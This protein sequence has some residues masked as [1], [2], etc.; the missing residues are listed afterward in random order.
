MPSE[1]LLSIGL[2]VYNGERFLEEALCSIL[3]QTFTD[4][5]LI[6]SD[7]ASSDRTRQ[8]AEAYAERDDRIRYYQSEK[9]MGAGWNMRRVYELAAGKYFK[10]AAVDDLLEPDLLQRCVGIL[11]GDPDCVL[12]YASTKEVDENRI[13]IKNYRTPTKTD[14]T[15]PVARFRE[16][17]LTGHNCYQIFGVIRMSAL[18]QLPPQGTYVNGDRILL[19]RLALLGRFYE[20]PEYLFISRHHRGQ[21]VATLPV[22]L[23]TRRFRLTNRYGT[24]PCTEWWEPAKTRTVSF[25]EFRELLEYSLSIYRTP[26]TARQKLRCY[27]LLLSW[28]DLHFKYMLR[29]LPI[30][31]DQALYNWQIGHTTS[32]VS[33]DPP[34]RSW[35]FDRN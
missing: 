18:R 30:A 5:E 2:Y 14:S 1:T 15:D 31:A 10:W 12:A 22:R 26:L 13:F 28:I 29:E 35:R 24:L 20:V 11:E 9:N 17:I 32:K 23:K 16:M 3:N 7:N 19:A 6:I 25:P 27:L 8:I 4:F 34:D 33:S 21:S